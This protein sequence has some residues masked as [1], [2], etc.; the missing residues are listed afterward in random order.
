[1]FLFLI[2]TEEDEE[3]E[4]DEDE[5]EE[6]LLGSLDRERDR[7]RS[8]RCAHVLSLVRDRP[9]LV[10]VVVVMESLDDDFLCRSLLDLVS[11]SDDCD[12]ADATDA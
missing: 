5:E 11:I 8:L 12:A 3:D 9:R 1:M 4:D 6:N 10:V 2:T 7:E